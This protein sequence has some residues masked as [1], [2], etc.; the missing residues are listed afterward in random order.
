MAVLYDEMTLPIVDNDLEEPK[1]HS[2]IISSRQADLER[3]FAF[4]DRDSSG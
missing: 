2:N 4:L 1:E 3:C